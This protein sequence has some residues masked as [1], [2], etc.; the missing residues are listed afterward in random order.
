MGLIKRKENIE[1]IDTNI[2]V[3]LITKDNP[4]QVQKARKLFA[5]QKKLFVFED[6]AMMEVVFVLSSSTYNFTREQIS[7]DIQN[8]MRIPNL[9]CNKGIIEAALD[10]YVSHPKLSFVDCYLAITAETS[11]E[12]PLWTLDRKLAA[13]CPVAKAL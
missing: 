4:V 9:I 10:I 7:R 11:Q 5:N 12:T 2:L 13:Q 1:R 6:A 8:L 3:R